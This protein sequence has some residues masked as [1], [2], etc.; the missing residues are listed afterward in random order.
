MR[1]EEKHEGGVVPATA[2]D[3]KQIVQSLTW[4]LGRNQTVSC[5]WKQMPSL[6][7]LVNLVGQAYFVDKYETSFLRKQMSS[8]SAISDHGDWVNFELWEG[9]KE[10]LYATFVLKWLD[11]FYLSYC[12]KGERLQYR[13]GFNSKHSKDSC[14]YITNTGQSEGVRRWKITKRNLISYSVCV[15]PPGSAG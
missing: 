12:S 1:K 3:R 11:T 10:K 13:I 15:T 6:R 2:G 7:W 8:L 9:I 5:L 14:K 4:T